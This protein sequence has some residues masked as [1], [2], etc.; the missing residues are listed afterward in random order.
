MRAIESKHSQQYTQKASR[1]RIPSMWPSSNGQL[2]R[3]SKSSEGS[4]CTN[5]RPSLHQNR[6]RRYNFQASWT[7]PKDQGPHLKSPSPE[8]WGVLI[9][10]Q[11]TKCQKEQ[12]VTGWRCTFVVGTFAISSAR[13]RPRPGGY[14]RPAPQLATTVPAPHAPPPLP[15][16]TSRCVTIYSTT[17]AIPIFRTCWACGLQHQCCDCSVWPLV[18]VFCWDVLWP[19]L[20]EN[21]KPSYHLALF[22][23]SIEPASVFITAH[24][25]NH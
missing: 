24:A 11:G 15:R 9:H 21:V 13:M 20:Q 3:P 19:A 25:C 16:R 18:L 6:S 23:Q 1:P 12:T 2:S 7:C 17:K 5:L 8:A 4:A 14:L 22:N 10:V